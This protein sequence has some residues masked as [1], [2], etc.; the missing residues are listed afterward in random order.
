VF[1][2]VP[3]WSWFKTN[4]HPTHGSAHISSNTVLTPVVFNPTATAK[5]IEQCSDMNTSV[6]L[7][8]EPVRVPTP[9]PG[10]HILTKG[11]SQS[12]LAV[13]CEDPDGNKGTFGS[14]GFTECQALWFTKTSPGS[15]KLKVTFR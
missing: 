4:Y 12:T 9:F 1:V 8:D 7:G 14:D 5:K 11:V 10:C 3:V 6:P 13:E 15:G 2:V